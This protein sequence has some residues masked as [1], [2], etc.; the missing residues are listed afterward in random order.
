MVSSRAP[1][2]A[3]VICSLGI[4]HRVSQHDSLEAQELALTPEQ[5]EV[6]DASMFFDPFDGFAVSLA[7]TADL[8]E[9]TLAS[10]AG[11]AAKNFVVA[12]DQQPGKHDHWNGMYKLID[13]SGELD[14]GLAC[15]G[16]GYFA[17]S[18]AKSSRY[19]VGSI[20]Q[21]LNIT[22]HRLVITDKGPFILKS[23][24]RKRTWI[25]GGPEVQIKSRGVTSMRRLYF[26]GDALRYIQK[27]PDQVVLD[28]KGTMDGDTYKIEGTCIPK[29]KGPSPK[30]THTFER[31]SHQSP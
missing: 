11:D 18:L 10:D 17:R 8:S 30:T 1:L 26:D 25:M 4:C 2:L 9:D 31:I 27:L 7:E 15:A 23:G 24:G 19:G 3:A 22:G 13:A 29:G 12:D 21:G 28:S 20:K 6:A 16:V 14:A 5:Q